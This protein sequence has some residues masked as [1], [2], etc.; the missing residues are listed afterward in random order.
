M[1]IDGE[2]LVFTSC[3]ECRLYPSERGGYITECRGADMK[4]KITAEKFLKC[5]GAA[6]EGDDLERCNCHLAGNV[7]HQNCGWDEK[8]NMPKFI[9]GESKEVLT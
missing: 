1:G 7:Y 3:N 6:P 4:T 2:R 5:V 9:P 8:R